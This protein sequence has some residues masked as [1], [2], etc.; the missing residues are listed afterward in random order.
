MSIIDFTI[1]RSL[2]VLVFMPKEED[3][4]ILTVSIMV[5]RLSMKLSEWIKIGE[6]FASV[7]FRT[8]EFMME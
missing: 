2:H 7:K 5:E 6:H 4:H 8:I 3:R 1:M